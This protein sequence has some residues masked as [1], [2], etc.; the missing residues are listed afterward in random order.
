MKKKK[1]NFKRKIHKTPD[2]TYNVHTYGQG[3]IPFDVEWVKYHNPMEGRDQ[4][5]FLYTDKRTKKICKHRVLR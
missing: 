1:A 2:P 3:K 5:I 4:I